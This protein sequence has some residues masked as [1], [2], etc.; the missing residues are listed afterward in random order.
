LRGV[1]AAR[2]PGELQGI[3]TT[4]RLATKPLS[5]HDTAASAADMQL[6]TAKVKALAVREASAGVHSGVRTFFDK[7]LLR[8]H[9][10]CITMDDLI[11]RL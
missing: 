11:P 4:V 7:Q 5:L 9:V 6:R 10:S 1:M 8:S 2:H 3:M